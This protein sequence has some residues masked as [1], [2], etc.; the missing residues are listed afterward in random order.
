MEDV[1]LTTLAWIMAL[2][3]GLMAGI[4][5]AF[6]GFIMRSIATIGTA[7]AITAMNAI[8]T[9]ILKSAFMPLFFGSTIVAIDDGHCRPLAVG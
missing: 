2:C 6:S 8:N 9:V 5:A 4:Y 1:Y 3:A 7:S